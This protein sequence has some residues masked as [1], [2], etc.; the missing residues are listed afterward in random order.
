MSRSSEKPDTVSQGEAQSATPH[1]HSVSAS[2]DPIDVKSHP[3]LPALDHRPFFLKNSVLIATISIN[4]SWIVWL[5]IA[6]T[7]LLW[8]GPNFILNGGFSG[9]VATLTKYFITAQVLAI[10]K[11]MPYQNMRWPKGRNVENTIDSDYWPYEWPILRFRALRNRDYFFQVMDIAAF[12]FTGAVVQFESNMMQQS[13][14]PSPPYEFLGYSP[15]RGII[16]IALICHC[17]FVVM[18][19]AILLW[20]NGRGTGLLADPG[21]LALYLALFNRLDIQQDFKGL[22]DEDRRWHVRHHLKQNQYRI[23]FWK[24]GGKVVYGIRRKILSPASFEVEPPRSPTKALKRRKATVYPEF[25][26]VPWFLQTFWLIIWMSVLASSLAIL[27][28]L[29]IRDSILTWGFNPRVS[30]N[31]SPFVDISPASFLWSFFPSFVAEIFAM[32]VLSI[33]TFYRLVQ[34]YADL[35][36]RNASKEVI[37]NAFSINYTNDLPFIVTWRAY[38]NK[39]WRVAVTSFFSFISGLTPAAAANMFYVD[40]NNWMAVWPP[41]F[42]S[43]I[44]YMGVLLIFL[45]CLIPDQSCYMPR[46]LE[47]IADHM[48]LFSQS[49]L[50]DE[51]TF[52]L[53]YDLGDPVKVVPTSTLVS[54]KK[55][56]PSILTFIT[57]IPS[58]LRNL[59]IIELKTSWTALKKAVIGPPELVDRVSE[60]MSNLNDNRLPRFGI[61]KRKGEW[62]VTIDCDADEKDKKTS[63]LFEDDYYRVRWDEVWKEVV[64]SLF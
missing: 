64:E 24:K 32:L 46:D 20:L 12:L 22:E 6:Y 8:R 28:T 41:Y 13:Y 44:T 62:A 27:S 43:M 31:I 63:T 48:A 58:K 5:A 30:T 61:W 14:D 45:L 51:P 2:E 40:D 34:P 42:W 50:L 1:R 55:A 37:I 25:R 10:G 7:R 47:T 4:L 39:H 26:Y 36:R 29:V 33:D 15:N 53:D 60:R 52:D 57:S 17:T 35:K 18:H 49:S 9:Y 38:H 59:R 19:V 21:S 3:E 16:I 23:G 56:A 11:I 54:L